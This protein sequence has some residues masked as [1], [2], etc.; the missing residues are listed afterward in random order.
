MICSKQS[1]AKKI[2][3]KPLARKPVVPN[4]RDNKSQIETVTHRATAWS[5]P[6]PPPSVLADFG[7]VVENGAER[8]M[9]AWEA[10]TAHRRKIEID[11]LRFSFL[12][13]MFGKISALIFVLAALGVT[14]YSASIGAQW[15]GVVLGGGVIGSVVWAFVN[16]SKSKKN[17]A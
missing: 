6:L 10:E 12:D 7:N 17:D 5:G 16:A 9:I 4:L 14:A 2:V 3:K 8:I 1:R 15:I 13:S 11:S